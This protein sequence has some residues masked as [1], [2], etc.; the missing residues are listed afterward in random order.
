MKIYPIFSPD[1]LRKAPD[2]PLPGQIQE[3]KDPIIINEQPEWEVERIIASRLHYRKLQY[4]AK[5]TGFDND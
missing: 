4:R 2:D 5:W 3:P 1:K